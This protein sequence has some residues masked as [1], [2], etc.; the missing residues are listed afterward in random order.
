MNRGRNRAVSRVPSALVVNESGENALMVK[1][2]LSALRIP[3]I[4]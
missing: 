2:G 4:S 3:A 1:A